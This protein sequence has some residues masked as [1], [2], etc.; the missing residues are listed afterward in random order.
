MPRNSAPAAALAAAAL[1]AGCAQGGLPLGPAV[2]VPA[3]RF[4]EVRGQADLVVRAAIPAGEREA[5]EVGGAVCEVSTILFEAQLTTP[6]RLVV[7]S[8]GPQSPTL[9]IDC[10]A[11]ELRGRA[12]RPVVT[13]W[14]NA[15]GAW[16]GPGPWGPGYG[17]GGWGGWGGP[18]GWS[19]PSYPV[20]EYP[21][22]TVMLR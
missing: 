20:F 5:R 13:R 17:Y 19:G 1:L 14:V 3:A 2:A 21:D 22:V 16:P 11:G 4:A 8:F 10:R 7:P 9:V 18:W 15:P 12:E 6:A